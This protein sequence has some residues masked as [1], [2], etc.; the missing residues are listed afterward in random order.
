MRNAANAYENSVARVFMFTS[1]S[2]SNNYD[3]S[4]IIKLYCKLL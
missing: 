2:Y 1:V 3:G 4:I